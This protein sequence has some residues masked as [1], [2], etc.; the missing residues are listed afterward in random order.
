[1]V[2]RTSNYKKFFLPYVPQAYVNYIYIFYLYIIAEQYED[3]SIKQ[4]VSYTSITDLF[5]KIN[6]NK[7]LLS[8]NEQRDQK[9]MKKQLI[10][11]ST[12]RRMLNDDEYKNFFNTDTCGRMNWIRLNNDFCQNRNKTE[13]KKF[14]VLNPKTYS[15]LIQ[16]DDNLLAKYTIFM[17][18]M[19]GASGGES[20]F[21]AN[22][23]FSAIGY[24][25]FSNSEKDAISK[26]NRLLEEN[27]IVKIERSQLED[28]KRRNRY[29]FIDI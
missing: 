6:T 13:K 2:Q 19:C 16:Q 1:M 14:V 22:Q 23:F 27:E 8:Y 25:T 29:R 20:D 26:Y 3:R 10:S 21:T 24:S 5:R 15:F 18:Y 9:K 17:R 4:D 7:K 11:Y 28:G 12:L